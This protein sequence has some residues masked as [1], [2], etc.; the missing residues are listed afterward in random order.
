MD[1]P[2]ERRIHSPI[3]QGQHVLLRPPRASDKRDRLELGRDSE[4]RKMVG[5]NSEN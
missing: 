2:N 1:L 3:L 4:F 5:A